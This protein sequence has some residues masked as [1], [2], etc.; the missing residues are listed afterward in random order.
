MTAMISSRWIAKAVMW[1]ATTPSSH[2]TAS[3]AAT[4]AG[5][6]DRGDVLTVT[7]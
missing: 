5:D 6:H 1:K 4:M 3:T 2:N 7:N